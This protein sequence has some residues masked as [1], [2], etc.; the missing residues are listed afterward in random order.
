MPSG[1]TLGNL[2]TVTLNWGD[3]SGALVITPPDGSWVQSV[4][5]QSTAGAACAVLYLVVDSGHA[6]QTSWSF[7]FN[8][9][10]NGNLCAQEWSSTT[11]WPAGSLTDQTA[12]N[13]GSG[14][15]VDSGTTGTTTVASELWLAGLCQNGT[16]AWSGVTSGWSSS[17][18]NSAAN[19]LLT[20]WKMVA[21]TGTADVSA[22][23]S[24]STAWGG[25]V[26]ALKAVQSS[27]PPASSA[28]IAEFP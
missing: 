28:L 7:A 8:N 12:T 5:H 21:S 6:G 20:A 27:P 19:T 23:N 24:V 14:T 4:I 16:G 2:L 1:I 11:G 22:T 9:A 13:S 26:T 25:V 10:H 18:H 3:S 15:A 17:S